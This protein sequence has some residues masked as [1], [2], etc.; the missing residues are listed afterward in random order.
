MPTID[1]GPPRPGPRD[2]LVAHHR[3]VAGALV[4]PAG[5]ALDHLTPAARARPRSLGELMSAL[6]DAG[7]RVLVRRT[8]PS[9]YVVLLGS[10]GPPDPT[11][12]DGPRLVAADLAA[13]RL[14]AVR[15]IE[16][17]LDGDD[18]ARVLLVGAGHGGVLAAE[19]AAAPLSE[20]FTVDGLVVAGAPSAHAPRIPDRVRV[21][22]L[23]DRDDPVALLGSLVNAGAT[24]RTDVVFDAGG[25]APGEAYLAGARAAD[26][27]AAHHPGLSAELDRLRAWGYLT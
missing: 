5:A 11:A 15:T 18:D 13:Y 3:G 12:G 17:A 16:A 4:E 14:G 19:L 2:L 20:A 25:A 21:L 7:D 6:L 8:A 10:P 23:E 27:A 26:E 1:L 22:S 9:R 24:N